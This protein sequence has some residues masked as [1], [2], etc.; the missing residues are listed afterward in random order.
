LFAKS[1]LIAEKNAPIFDKLLSVLMFYALIWVS[2]V[3]LV[4]QDW[5]TFAVFSQ[6]IIVPPVFLLAGIAAW[7]N[8]FRPARFFL[9]AFAILALSVI[10]ESLVT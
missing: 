8:G 6:G 2:M 1:F 4:D 7:K 5:V 9:F 3:P 10:F